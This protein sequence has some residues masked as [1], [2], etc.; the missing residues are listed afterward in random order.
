MSPSPGSTDTGLSSAPSPVTLESAEPARTSVWRR[1]RPS[2]RAQRTD[3]AIGI[4]LAVAGAFAAELMRSAS[5][6]PLD[7]GA[8][9]IE[10]YFLSAAVPLTLCFRRRFPLA[11][12]L[13]TSVMFFIAGERLPLIGGA[14][15]VTQVTLFMA[16]YTA[17]A[18]AQDRKR[19][20][21]TIIFVVVSM[22]IW[23]AFGFVR[24][25]RADE[26]TGSGVDGLLSPYVAYVVHNIGINIAYFVGSWL[27]GLTAWRTA[28][29]HDELLR[30]AQELAEQQQ[31]NA[32]RA[33]IDERLR[34]S[35]ELHDVVAHHISSI[36]VQAGGARRVMDTNPEAAKGALSVIEESSRTAVNEMR[37]L[38]GMLRAADPDLDEEVGVSAVRAPQANV[39][40]LPA[41]VA[42]A[43]N[44]QLSVGYHQIGTT[45]KLPETV[46]VSVYR[47]VQEALTNVRRHSTARTANVTLRYLEDAVEIEVIDDGRP[48]HAP[49]GSRLGHVGIRERVALLGGESE[50]GP[51]SVG[52][53]RVRARFPVKEQQL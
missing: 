52:G 9:G 41:L 10:G 22:F 1:P 21:I 28:R 11:T 19:F 31:G 51:R 33:V 49:V 43:S 14:N 47:I 8:G 5:P 42:D 44:E 50:I 27:W 6:Q 2:Q 20:Q 40:R 32:R 39:D 30:Q 36:G 35:R 3:I 25:L 46:S 45:Q 29:Q 37:Q 13:A 12:L 34:I 18:W 17:A 7:M 23:L 24:A 15:I 26:I 16:I 4:A 53:F 38:L 48:K